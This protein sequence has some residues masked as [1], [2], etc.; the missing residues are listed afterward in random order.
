M[1][2]AFVVSLG[3]YLA[4]LGAEHTFGFELDF[5]VRFF[6]FFPLAILMSLTV[7]K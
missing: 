1:A 5:W 7:A 6:I 3:V 2:K 4:V